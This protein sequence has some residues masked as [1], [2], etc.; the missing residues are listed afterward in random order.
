MTFRS[1][2]KKR[3]KYG[4]KPTTSGC[5][6]GHS[7]RSK[8]ENA[9]CSMLYLRYLAGEFVSIHA[10]KH[11]LICGPIGHE[12]DHKKKIELVVDFQ[13]TRKDGSILNAEAKGFANDRWPMKLRL[14][15]HWIKDTL[16]IWKGSATRPVLSETING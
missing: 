8:L 4:N 10:E 16:E 9:V 11:I 3:L 6:L 1:Y 5:Q 13:C 14:Y 15:R 12:C 7:H 2:P